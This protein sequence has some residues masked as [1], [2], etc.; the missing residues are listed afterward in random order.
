MNG[1]KFSKQLIQKQNTQEK[2]G[3]DANEFY[4][5]GRL[6]NVSHCLHSS[7]ITRSLSTYLAV[8]SVLLM[9]S[10]TSLEFISYVLYVVKLHIK[11]SRF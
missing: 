9:L 8:L 10:Q 2:L 7:V 1:F 11:S 5:S 3:G 4:V 6:F